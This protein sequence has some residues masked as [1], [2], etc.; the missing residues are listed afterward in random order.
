MIWGA[1]NISTLIYV[2][3]SAKLSQQRNPNRREMR[4]RKRKRGGQ[5]MGQAEKSE[6]AK[7]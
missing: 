3:Q 4:N 6:V 2:S 7:T 5:K 1:V